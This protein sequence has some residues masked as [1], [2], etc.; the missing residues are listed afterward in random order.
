MLN[1]WHIRNRY[2]IVLTTALFFFGCKAELERF[3]L[4]QASVFESFDPTRWSPGEEP[5]RI[6]SDQMSEP[7]IFGLPPFYSRKHQLEMMDKLRAYLEIEVERPVEIVIADSYREVVERFIRGEIQLVSLPSVAWVMAERRL[8]EMKTLAAAVSEG[9]VT[10]A[11][12]FIVR[13]NSPIE[14][15]NDVLGK[16]IALTQ[17][18]S[19]SGYVKPMAWLVRQGY[20]P[21][22]DFQIVPLRQHDRALKALK[23]GQV[24]VAA[25]SSETLTNTSSLGVRGRFR[26]LAKAGRL[27]HDAI[28]AHPEVSPWLTY[29]LQRAFLTLS[30]HDP[31][32]ADILEDMH[33]ITGYMPVPDGHF[34]EMREMVETLKLW[35]SL[36]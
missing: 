29:R 11:S 22:R 20:V 30:I 18:W 21:E 23:R 10:Y 34:D 25:V 16:K 26:I 15:F 4:Q 14:K 36:P 8:P 28:V 33:S 31:K 24:D 1:F 19:S 35:E 6:A 17:A 7:I 13:E 32:G 5:E 27:P 2:W 9:G 3:P 12:Y